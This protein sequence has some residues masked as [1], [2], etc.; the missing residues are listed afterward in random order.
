MNK[1]TFNGHS[2]N[3]FGLL[4]TGLST[5]GAPSRRVERVSVP[6][7][8]G[9]VLLDDETYENY[10]AR[11]DVAIGNSFKANARAIANWLLSSRE[12]SVLTDTYNPESYRMASFYSNID[13]VVTALARYG[14]AS[15]EFDC[16]P[17][18]YMT[19]NN[20]V[21]V[22]ANAYEQTIEGGIIS[23]TADAP[24]LITLK[25]NSGQNGTPTPS[26]P[27]QIQNV[28]GNNSISLIGKN[29]LNPAEVH[30]NSTANLKT[31]I[32]NGVVTL[33]AKTTSGAQYAVTYIYDLDSTK[34]YTISFKGMKLVDS[35]NGSV[36][37]FYVYGSNNGG[38]TWSSNLSNALQVNSPTLN[39][40]YEKKETFTGYSAYR[41]YMYNNGG[42]TVSVG[43]KTQYW[44][45]QLEYGTAATDY[46][47]YNPKEYPVDLPEDIEL[48]K[49]G[50]YQD[51]FYKSGDSWYLHK[52]TATIE[53]Y[54]GETVTT[55][56]MSTTGSLDTGAEVIYGLTTAENVLI[57]DKELINQLNDLAEA[58]A[59]EGSTTIKQTNTDLPFKLDVLAFTNGTLNLNYNAEPIIKVSTPGSICINGKVLTVTS[60]P[61]IINSQTMQSYYGN[62]LKNND[63]EGDYPTM[64]K[65]AN[66]VSSNINFTFTPNYW[67]L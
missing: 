58:K 37:R 21:S 65:G 34:S 53:S 62:V 19:T 4:V 50:D 33:T 57:E 67:E 39:T 42:G 60:A 25:G 66:I 10:I 29:K 1:F 52:E 20:D 56:Y 2:T 41:I 30:S 47:E 12:Y 17:Q 45:I 59:A 35:P 13:Y 16:K 43:E 7:R 14:T 18:R 46:E 6:G 22:T 8:N 11:Y 23:N 44:D 3:E 64:T 26:V 36:V 63:V 27:V 61:I 55:T 32:N 9:Y 31:D 40:V 28:S 38:T 5:Y 49:V 15:I 24:I 51:Y 48:N 54:D